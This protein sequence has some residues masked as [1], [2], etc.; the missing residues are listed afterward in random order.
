M[1]SAWTGWIVFAA[2][3]LAFVGALTFFEG[4]H[5]GH[6]GHVLRRQQAERLRVRR[7]DLGLDRDALGVLLFSPALGTG[8]EEAAGPAGSRSSSS[9]STCWPSSAGWATPVSA[10]SAERIVTPEIVV[11]Y[12]LTVRWKDVYTL[13]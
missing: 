10:W 9:S 3:M 5:R 13:E 1:S 2:I 4:P 11:L 8:G 12:A 6:Q 7:L